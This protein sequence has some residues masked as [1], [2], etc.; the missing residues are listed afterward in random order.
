MTSALKEI[1]TDSTCLNDQDSPCVYRLETPV[2]AWNVVGTF[3]DLRGQNRALSGQVDPAHAQS[4]EADKT[5]I[6][7]WMSNTGNDEK[8][9]PGIR[10]SQFCHN[11]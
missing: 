7:F 2:N 10:G 6:Q 8:P 1:V 5:W 11:F 9:N 3:G 4:V